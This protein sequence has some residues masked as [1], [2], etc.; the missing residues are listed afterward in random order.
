MSNM[1]SPSQTTPRLY[2]A[3]VWKQAGAQP[4]ERTSLLATS[5][6]DAKRQLRARFGEDLVFTLYN[7]DDA[8]QAR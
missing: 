4:G 2:E 6:E 8:D 1:S 3:I 5:L 7:Q